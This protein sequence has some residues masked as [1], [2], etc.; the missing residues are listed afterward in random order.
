MVRLHA[1]VLTLT[2]CRSR[3]YTCVVVSRLVH[4]R[5][6]RHLRHMRH[7][8]VNSFRHPDHTCVYVRSAR[9]PPANATGPQTP[10]VGYR[11]QDPTSRTLCEGLLPLPTFEESLGFLSCAHVRRP[12]F[13]E[14]AHAAK[15][16]ID[17][18]PLFSACPTDCP[19]SVR[20]L[21]PPQ[22]TK[23][24]RLTIA[25][26]CIEGVFFVRDIAPRI[27]LEVRR[28]MRRCRIGSDCLLNR[29]CHVCVRSSDGC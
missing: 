9:N 22:P 25:R 2:E 24:R 17:I 18:P 19:N 4:G 11:N 10:A 29:V 20:L 8:A 14:P 6:D 7:K 26:G 1:S 15:N 16:K 5:L 28:R 12:R 3:Q 27:R 13:V 23:K 21:V